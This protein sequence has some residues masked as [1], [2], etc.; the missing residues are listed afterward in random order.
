[1]I[2][3]LFENSGHRTGPPQAEPAPFSM[4]GA[5][6]RRL[7]V[8]SVGAHKL[9]LVRHAFALVEAGICYGRLDVPADVVATRACAEQLAG[10]LPGGLLITTSP[11]QRS[12]Q[13]A[14]VLAGLRPDLTI[15]I[16]H[17]LREMHFGNWEGRAWSDI[18]ISELDAWTAD[19]SSYRA[20]GTGECVSAFMDR[21]A[22]A[23]DTLPATSDMLWITHA[24][25]I[26]AAG[27]LAAGIRHP[28]RADQWPRD[29]LA[30]GQWCTLNIS[31]TGSRRSA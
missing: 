11:L 17:R 24:G 10:V 29:G 26:R 21:V 28:T 16:D 22:A 19:F 8:E 30:C 25:V 31:A 2:G 5:A 15:K 7:E 3:D 23:F 9:W 13:L 20:G 1:M 12:E 6:R 14:R 4:N 27:L 18:P